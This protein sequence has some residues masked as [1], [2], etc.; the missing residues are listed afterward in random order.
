MEVNFKTQI[1]KKENHLKEIALHTIIGLRAD[2]KTPNLWMPGL[3][4]SGSLI[5][6]IIDDLILCG[7]KFI[8]E[9]DFLC[10]IPNSGRVIAASIQQKLSI[11][12]ISYQVKDFRQKYVRSPFIPLEELIPKRAKVLLIDDFIETGGTLKDTINIFKSLKPKWKISGL[13]TVID[14]DVTSYSIDS[15]K[16]D[17]IKKKKLISLYK[18]SEFIKFSKY[19]N[20]EAHIKV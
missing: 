9:A 8:D 19:F 20:P 5:K 16:E 1:P 2:N 6:K 14:N 10:S 17:F 4:Y 3:F 11:N 18:S 13:L 7:M 15:K 12:I